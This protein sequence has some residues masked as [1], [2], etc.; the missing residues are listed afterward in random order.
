MPQRRRWLLEVHI[1][2]KHP[3]VSV[4]DILGPSPFASAGK[5]SNKNT[6]RKTGGTAVTMEIPKCSN[7]APGPKNPAIDTVI[8]ERTI[9]SSDATECSATNVTAA[10]SVSVEPYRREPVVSKVVHTDTSTIAITTVGCIADSKQ[11]MFTSS[12]HG[13][14]RDPDSHMIDMMGMSIEGEEELGKIEQCSAG[15]PTD[16]DAESTEPFVLSE[17]S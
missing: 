12:T 11:K 6:T 5:K 10:G 17:R 1:R 7:T 2:D 15:L 14:P 9:D 8:H 4:L 13:P 3:G 16:R